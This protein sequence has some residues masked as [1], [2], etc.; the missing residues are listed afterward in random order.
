MRPEPELL[1]AARTDDEL[2]ERVEN[3]QKYMPE[4]IEASV[5]ELQY[6]GKTFSDEELSYIKADVAARRKN[7]AT[8][9]NRMS[10]FNSDF[11]YTIVQDPDAPSLYSR[12]VIYIF[13][14]LMGAL[15]GA[16]MM[17]INI[18]KTN[19]KGVWPV[20]LFG[21]AFLT[22]QIFIGERFIT[23]S[24]EFYGLVCGIVA[25]YCLNYFFW[26]RYIGNTAF[27]RVKMAWGPLVILV[28]I[29]GLLIALFALAK[30]MAGVN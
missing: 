28:V 8:A 9:I 13:T 10:L 27:Y 3:R 15:F 6:R 24:V 7:A 26:N 12:R 4:T 1:A 14:V 23:G 17:A 29:L 5:E 2:M 25:A 22:V 21:V 20:I 19:R 16:I 30:S 11:K 18:N